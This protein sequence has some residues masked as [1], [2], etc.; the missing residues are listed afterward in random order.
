MYK[1]DGDYGGTQLAALRELCEETAS[2]FMIGHSNGIFLIDGGSDVLSAVSVLYAEIDR[3]STLDGICTAYIRP[4]KPREEII[5]KPPIILRPTENATVFRIY[6]G[7]FMKK[8]LPYTKV[9]RALPGHMSM[10]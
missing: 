6:G 2:T 4:V 5:A 7:S 3:E 8:A 1:S 10:P 9:R